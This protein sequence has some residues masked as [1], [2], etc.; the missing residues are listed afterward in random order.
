MKKYNKPT[1]KIEEINLNNNIAATLS[2]VAGVG[3]PQ[4]GDKVINF[5]SF[6]K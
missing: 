2:G 5:E 4:E 1:L 6:W 3:V